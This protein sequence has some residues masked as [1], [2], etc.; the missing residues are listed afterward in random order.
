MEDVSEPRIPWWIWAITTLLALLVLVA[1]AT[2][3]RVLPGHAEPLAPPTLSVAWAE[4]DV[5]ATTSRTTAVLVEV[6][7]DVVAGTEL[8]LQLPD[9][10][11][12]AFPSVCGISTAVDRQSWITDDG[13]E[14]HC[15]LPTVVS[16][17]PLSFRVAA[18]VDPDATAY[19]AGTA[20]LTDVEAAL[21]PREVVAGPAPAPRAMRILSS[22][23]FLN[24][25]VADL[26][27][28]ETAYRPGLH[29]NG[30]SPEVE[31]SLDTILGDWASRQPDDVLVA[32]D[33]VNGHWGLDRESTGIFG[34]VSTAAEKKAAIIR[35]ANTYYPQ[36]LTR[37]AAQGLETVHPAMGDHEYGDNDWPD[38][39]LAQAGTYRNAWERWFTRNADGSA[40]YPD[41][42]AS[43]QHALS[44]Y[45]WRPDPLVQMVTLDV[46]HRKPNRMLI[47]VD[48]AQ[49]A[50]LEGV[51]ARA[52]ADGVPWVIVQGHVPIVGPVR[53]GASSG[54]HYGRGAD[55][56]LWRLFRAYGVDVYLC[57]EVHDVT[58]I[59]RDGILQVSHGG[60][61]QFNRTNYLLADVYRNR[62]D[63]RILDYLDTNTDDR[64]VWETRTRYSSHLTYHPG[65]VVIGTAVLNAD[66]ALSR[67]SGA[68]APYTP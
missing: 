30:T 33:L 48:Q 12:V 7:G 50:W 24:T 57:G 42:P 10:T 47:H 16:S 35:A 61:F 67:V 38:W 55:S 17:L 66:H 46:F 22:P 27:L 9:A 41:H 21:P 45:A 52:Q 31:A 36:W 43:G 29:D 58:A 5:P 13:H 6:G 2:F 59:S 62:L 3:T 11:I 15:V 37:F 14:L 1:A 60:A 20:Y 44:A 64:D 25:D 4:G 65:P 23:D 54:L 18:N 39:K 53:S 68:L 56:D 28:G 51:L 49:F 40:R 32:G 8:V 19:V 63:L 26:A 34:P